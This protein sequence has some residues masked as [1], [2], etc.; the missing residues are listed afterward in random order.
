MPALA[1]AGHAVVA[2]E[3]GHTFEVEETVDA[4]LKEVFEQH[5]LGAVCIDVCRELGVTCLY[6]LETHVTAQDVDDKP[7]YVQDT[8]KQHRDQS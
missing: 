2:K 4:R 3:G 8:L 5:G 6:D 1:D 7:K